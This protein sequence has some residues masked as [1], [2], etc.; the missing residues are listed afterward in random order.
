M[1]P[2]H[3]HRPQRR[4]GRHVWAHLLHR[5]HG[6]PRLSEV[7]LP[8]GAGVSQGLAALRTLAVRR[9]SRS[10]AIGP[11]LAY[12]YSFRGIVPSRQFSWDLQLGQ[13]RSPGQELTK[14]SRHFKQ[15]RDLA[16]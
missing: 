9:M 4:R 15:R 7:V 2:H 10:E 11:A 16:S 5:A 8:G 1:A 12:L 14:R 13:T 6:F 3:L